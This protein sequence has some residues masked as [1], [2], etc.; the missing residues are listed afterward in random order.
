MVLLTD[1]MF[2]TLDKIFACELC[3]NVSSVHL[4]HNG[5]L[6]RA[7]CLR[8]SHTTTTG[9]PNRVEIHQLRII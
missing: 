4:C 7:W 3:H 5:S 8:L 1:S 9:L 2:S 6:L